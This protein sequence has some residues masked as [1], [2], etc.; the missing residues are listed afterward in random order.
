MKIAFSLGVL[1]LGFTASIGAWG[2]FDGAWVVV[3]LT[4]AQNV[5]IGVAL[6]ALA[7]SSAIAVAMELAE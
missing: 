3:G 5:L 4:R 6:A 2:L 1:A 7:V